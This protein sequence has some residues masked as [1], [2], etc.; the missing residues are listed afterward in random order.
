MKDKRGAKQ[1]VLAKHQLIGSIRL[2][3]SAVP[4]WH[5]EK[6]ERQ[7]QYIENIRPPEIAQFG[8]TPEMTASVNPKKTPVVY[9]SIFVGLKPLNQ[10][11][12]QD[13]Q[14]L[15]FIME[16]AL[17]RAAAHVTRK[18]HWNSAVRPFRVK[19]GIG[20][21]G[22]CSSPKEHTNLEK[23]NI[24]LTIY[25]PMPYIVMVPPDSTW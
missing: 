22:E 15:F 6:E 25:Q 14:H 17:G 12:L 3:L 23:K 20:V 5:S 1:V 19:R 10:P 18:G 13:D 11:R 9:H 8:T 4:Q 7:T 24:L 21:G 2:F 16:A